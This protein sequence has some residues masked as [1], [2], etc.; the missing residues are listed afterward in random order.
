MSEITPEKL[1]SLAKEYLERAVNTQHDRGMLA[2]H[3]YPF[4]EESPGERLLPTLQTTEA[5]IGWVSEPRFLDS[6]KSGRWLFLRALRG[7]SSWL[8][9]RGVTEHHVHFY[10]NTDHA[11][12]TGEVPDLALKFNLQR[13]IA[14]F[15]LSCPEPST[16]RTKTTIWAAHNFNLYRNRPENLDLSSEDLLVGWLQ[17]ASTTL[18]PKGTASMLR[19]LVRFNDSVEVSSFL[20]DVGEWLSRYRSARAVTRNLEELSRVTKV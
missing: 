17:E 2:R 10:V 11:V 14:R 4:L 19:G 20:P 5:L 18:T 9:K 16:A 7:F 12:R 15:E 6:S 8:F 3:L 1:L 13:D